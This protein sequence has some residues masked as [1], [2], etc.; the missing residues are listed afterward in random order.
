M[1]SNKIGR[2]ALTTIGGLILLTTI[3]LAWA[4]A[5]TNACALLSVGQVGTILG[6]QVEAGKNLI[7]PNDCRWKQMNAKPGSDAAM[8]QVNLSKAQSFEIG[9]TVIPNWTKTPITGLGDDAYSADQ[10]GKMTFPISPSLSVKKGAVFLV[11]SAK[12]PKA[13]LEQ[14]KDVEKRIAGAI[15]D[16]L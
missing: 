4:A 16:T 6:V 15:L 13:T 14:T 10:G 2:T 11:I 1:C 5:P 7:S 9:K 8:L 12:V 3:P